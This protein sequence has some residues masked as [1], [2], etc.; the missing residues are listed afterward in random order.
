MLFVVVVVVVSYSGV[1]YVCHYRYTIDID[2]EI[3]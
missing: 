3:V 2:K 1:G